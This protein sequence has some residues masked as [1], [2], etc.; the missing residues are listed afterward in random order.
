MM[1]NQVSPAKSSIEVAR[2]DVRRGVV[3]QGLAN[4]AARA[5]ERRDQ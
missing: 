1:D 2:V 5:V 4:D 3:S